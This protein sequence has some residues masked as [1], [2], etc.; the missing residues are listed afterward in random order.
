MILEADTFTIR[1]IE[2]ADA[3]NLRYT[4]MDNHE[5]L[6]TDFPNMVDRYWNEETAQQSARRAATASA[7]TQSGFCAWVATDPE[8]TRIYGVATKSLLTMNQ[9]RT[10][11]VFQAWHGSPYGGLLSVHALKEAALV[12]GWTSKD[13]PETVA[14][15]GLAYVL[16]QRLRPVDAGEVAMNVTLIRPEN[17]AAARVASKVGM[18]RATK[19]NGELVSAVSTPRQQLA[20]LGDGITQP[21]NLW[22]HE[23]PACG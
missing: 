21:R 18:H 23:D 15:Q 14:T 8:N 10:L 17:D 11:K 3:R 5:R 16:T 20:R 9:Q 1:P 19:R 6:T 7:D 13:R 4:V 12:A 2:A 22:V